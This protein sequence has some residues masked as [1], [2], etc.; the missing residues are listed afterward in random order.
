MRRIGITYHPSSPLFLSGLNQTALLFADLF[1]KLDYHVTLVD[2]KNS[3]TKWWPDYPMTNLSTTNLYQTK[4]LDVLLDIDGLV[5]PENRKKAATKTIAFFRTFMQFTEM[6][7]SVYIDTPYVPRSMDNVDEVWCWDLLNPPETIPSIQTIFPLIKRVPFIWSSKI[8]E[9]YKIC[10]MSYNN[11]E[12]EQ[13]TVHVAEKNTN[14]SSAIFP[15]V[16]IKELVHKKV[17]D[18][19]YKVHNMDII[20]ENKFFKENVAAAIELDKLPVELV[21]KEPFYT[22]LPHSI[23]FSHS[24]F[25][26]L[27]IGLLNAIYLGIPVIH[28]SPYLRELHPVLQSMYYTGNNM[29]E[30]KAAFGRFKDTPEKWFDAVKEIR[31][32]LAIL[33]TLNANEEWVTICNDA[34]E[35]NQ[36]VQEAKEAKQAKQEAKPSTQTTQVSQVTTQVTQKIIAFEDMW[37]GFNCD[38]NF[39]MDALRNALRNALHSTTEIHL[40]GVPYSS[41]YEPDLLIF[42]PYSNKWKLV[43]DAIPKVYFSAENWTKPYDPQVKLYMTSSTEENEV[44]MRIPT[45]ITFIDWFSTSTELP[46]NQTDNPI[47]IPLH[48]AMTPHPKPFEERKEFCAFVVSNPTCSFRNDTF[49]LL[50]I[51]KKVNSG[52]QLYNNIGQPLSMLYPGGGCG[53][54]SKYK[55]FEDH[56]FT[57]SFENSQSPG[58]ITEKVLHAKMAGCVPIYW[59]DKNTSTDFVANSF[60]NVSNATSPELVVEIIKKLEANPAMCAKIAATPI[61]DETKKLAALKII[62]RM[63]RRLL[64]LIGVEASE[65]PEEK[66]EEKIEVPEVPEVPEVREVQEVQEI[67]GIDK[68][69][70]INLDTRPD[71]W[72]KLMKSE[73]YLDNLVT[74]I[75][76]VNGK[77]LKMSTFIYDLFNKNQFQWKKSVIGCNLS[78]ISTWAKIASGKGQYYL[79]LEDDVRFV[80][81]WLTTWAEYV[82]HIPEDADLL[83]LGGVLPPNKRALPSASAEYNKYWS[84][85]KPN[86][87]FSPSPVAIFHFCAYS[88]ILTPRGAQKLMYYLGHSESK[89]FTVSD[90]LLGHPSVG[91]VKYFTNPLLSYCFQEEDPVYVNSQFNDLHRED[92]FDSDLWNNKECFSE[93]ELAPFRE[94]VQNTAEVFVAESASNPVTKPSE[95]LAPLRVYYM[96]NDDKPLH[97]YEQKWLEDI[98]GTTLQFISI[99]SHEIIDNS[100][101]LLQRPHSEKMNHFFSILND[102]GIRFKVL[103][104]SD[105]FATD[106]ISFYALPLCKAVVRNYLRDVPQ[107]PHIHTIPLGYHHKYEGALK[108]WDERELVWSFHGTDWFD[109]ATQ[110]RPLTEYVPFSCSLQ[111]SWNHPTAIKEKKYLSLLGNSKF[112]PVLKGNN[113]ET[114]RFYEALE[115]GSLPVAMEKNAYTEWIDSQMDLS[116]LYEWTNPA[117]MNMAMSDTV[118]KMVLLRWKEW[119]TKMNRMISQ[120]V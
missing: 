81:G 88:Y 98:M 24:R 48:F 116:S 26:P 33:D 52:G 47:R 32:A 38:T 69:Y 117:V 114:F 109:R 89:S 7:A 58:Y 104:V 74:R 97:L 6:D 99:L 108:P 28:N 11:E 110:L 115:A 43:P 87:F 96:P 66:P 105:E 50:N 94:A 67:A 111:P 27:R 112:C 77:S 16:A 84:Y 35:T 71:R 72:E 54:I 19:T 62:S 40:K 91:L 8:A 90:H 1:T 22:W 102:R 103:H 5:N 59:G 44:N 63:A 64:G 9:H 83:Y 61:L 118:Y 20:K 2:Y 82:K 31:G 113:M 93:E 17:I 68:I 14:M 42:G 30:I 120:Y 57:I 36:G 92:T 86:T 4:G 34:F 12:K 80:K 15:L 70:V 85:I 107:L 78:H 65:K 51:Y 60:I 49:H 21:S 53:D 56:K 76:A 119:K 45:W 73:P 39:I 13:W 25:T 41:E 23:L 79:V 10:D 18:A 100:W 95:P 55:F 106:V 37:P 75:A 29:G 101:Y 3:E 46:V